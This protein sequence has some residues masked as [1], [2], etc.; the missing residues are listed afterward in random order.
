[1]DSTACTVQHH[2]QHVD[3]VDGLLPMPTNIKLQMPILAKLLQDLAANLGR[4]SVQL[5][6]KASMDLRRA[7]DADDYQAVRAVYRRGDGWVSAVENGFC[8]GVPEEAMKAF[9]RR[10]RGNHGTR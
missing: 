8:V 9:A 7:Y 5:Q 10:H 1:M 4:E 3:G 2:G 6:L